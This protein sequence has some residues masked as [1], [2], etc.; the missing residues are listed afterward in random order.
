M[1]PHLARAIAV[2]RHAVDA[3]V[4]AGYE[5]ERDWQRSRD[6]GH[7]SETDFLRETAW[8]IL[9]SGFRESVVRR[10][11]DYLSLCFCDWSSA[12]EIIGNEHACRRSA[13]S[14]FG[15]QRKIDAIIS[16]AAIVSVTGFPS[17]E[18]RIQCDPINTLQRFE[19]IGAVTALHLA[20]NLGFLVA[21]PDRH[22]VRLS[23]R[24]GFSSTEELCS[25]LALES[26]DPVNVVDVTLW[27]YCTLVVQH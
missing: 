6:A 24:L 3:A 11:F 7:F 25:A 22:L 1:K 8:V 12:D 10:N 2:Y 9:C 13:L 23:E 17:I 27:R 15:N 20:K 14:A 5:S 21:K 16:A 19:F 4:A 26:G 18:A